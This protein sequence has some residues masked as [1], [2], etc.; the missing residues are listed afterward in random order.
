[1]PED[2]IFEPN[3]AI[4]PGEHILE[5]LE[6]VQPDDLKAFPEKLGLSMEAV[7]RLLT[8]TD[9]VTQELAEKLVAFFGRGS[10]QYWLNLESNYRTSLAHMAL[11]EKV[12]EAIFHHDGG[13]TDED[14][15][16]VHG[17]SRRLWKTEEAWDTQPEVELCE[18]ERDEYRLMARAAMKVLK[19]EWQHS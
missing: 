11:T 6:C 13:M 14:Y 4:P 3:W 5:W 18:H 10:V 9:P 1:M 8:G 16:L 19:R 17:K 2:E 12:A 15:L 7:E